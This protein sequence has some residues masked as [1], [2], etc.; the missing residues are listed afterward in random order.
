MPVTP[1][2]FTLT[3][4]Q[5]QFR[6][7]LNRFPSL[8]SFW[9]F[10]TRDCDVSALERAIPVMSHGEQIMARFVAAV[11]LGENRFDFDLIDA[12][13]TLDDTHRQLITDWLLNPVFP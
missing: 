1:G 4:E 7:L 3:R 9:N 5:R 2:H 8:V 11:W 6:Q 13:A 12:A 10:Q